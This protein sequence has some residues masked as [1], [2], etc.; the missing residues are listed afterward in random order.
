MANQILYD[1]TT[2]NTTKPAE[3]WNPYTNAYQDTNPLTG[4]PAGT[5]SGLKA[6][7]KG[8]NPEI[9]ANY[10]GSVTVVDGMVYTSYMPQDQYIADNTMKVAAYNGFY[11][12]TLANFTGTTTETVIKVTAVSSN[13][14]YNGAGPT[15]YI[16]LYVNG[17][18][19]RINFTNDGNPHEVDVNL[20]TGTK[21]IKF[22]L[23]D[24]GRYQLN[25]QTIAG[26]IL[27]DIRSIAP[28]NWESPAVLPNS[29]LFIGD[30]IPGGNDAS[31]S[32]DLGY[33]A[34]IRKNLSS[35]TRIVLDTFSGGSLSEVYNSS[36][37]P[38]NKVAYIN[39]LGNAQKGSTTN[40]LVVAY[41]GTNDQG[42]GTATAS[43]YATYLDN[44]LTDY[45]TAFPTH[46]II[47]FTALPNG[48][49]GNEAALANDYRPAARSVVAS[50]SYVNL[51]EG[52]DLCSLA[53]INGNGPHPTTAGH[54]QIANNFLSIVNPNNR[55]IL[56][57]YKASGIV[58]DSSNRI[59]RWNDSGL[60]SAHIVNND[61]SNV[62]SLS[63]GGALFT[64]TTMNPVTVPL[65]ASNSNGGITLFMVMTK[66]ASTRV[67]SMTVAFSCADGNNVDITYINDGPGMTRYGLNT[68]TGAVSG[69][70]NP[71]AK[72]ANKI[73]VSCNIRP[74]DPNNFQIYLNGVQEAEANT[75]TLG[76]NGNPVNDNHAIRA[77]SGFLLLGGPNTISHDGMIYHVRV[78]KLLNDA[79]RQ[80]MEA[81]IRTENGI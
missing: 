61:M 20:G 9:V 46:K 39:R 78:C 17:V 51:I 76:N 35:D 34:L 74:N 71:S 49:S 45:H 25:T 31:E 77:L 10:T 57:D 65:L 67:P 53:N 23:H 56:A 79:D 64:N 73:L 66:D 13:Y 69:F 48:N 70:T 47:Y 26:A 21:T 63:N 36:L 42:N 18:Y 54:Q 28:I 11:R 81:S 4:I 37:T 6:R 55:V 80:A 44:L 16:G 32:A 75:P 12:S 68:Y 62:P 30:S 43:Q 40:T 72:L 5:Y 33:T 3:Y 19:R 14:L 2:S 24:L 7:L 58:A 29:Y 15:D 41:S 8:S 50:K 59:T 22:V 38:A 60:G 52:S 1:V 27:L